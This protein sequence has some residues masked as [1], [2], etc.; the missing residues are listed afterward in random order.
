[1][2]INIWIISSVSVVLFASALLVWHVHE[3]NLQAAAYAMGHG[4]AQSKHEEDEVDQLLESIKLENED[5]EQRA[6]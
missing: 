3:H 1:M 5:E 4:K 2:K 6:P